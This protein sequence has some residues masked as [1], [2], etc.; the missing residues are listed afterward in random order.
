MTRF[1]R[2]AGVS[3]LAIC[4]SLGAMA[5]TV[6]YVSPGGDDTWAGTIG[7]PFKTLAKAVSVTANNSNTIIYLR[8]GMHN[9]S[10]RVVLNNNKNGT[11]VNRLRIFAYPGDPRPVLNFTALGLGSGNQGI[12]IKGS[13]WHLKGFDVYGAGDNGIIIEGGSNNIIENCAFYENQDSGLQI[14][15][16]AANNQIINCDSYFN[17]DATDGNAD[18]FACKLLAGTGNSFKGCRAWQNSDDGW[19]GLLTAP[20]DNI[21]TTYDSCWCFMNGYL[22]SGVASKGN[23]NGFKMGGNELRHNA[24]LTRCLSFYNRVKGF[25]QNNDIGDMILYNC[26]GYGN[27]PNFG[28]NNFDPAAGKVMEIR[29]SI[30]FA[31]K[32]SDVFR[33]VAI[34]TNN[35]WQSPFVTTAA[36]FL[37]VDTTGIRGP[38]KADGSLPDVNFMHLAAGSDL[39][40]GGMLVNLPYNGSAPDLGAFETASVLPVKLAGFSAVNKNKDVLLQWTLATETNNRGWEIERSLSGSNTWEDLGFVAGTGNSNQLTNYSFL[41]VSPAPGTYFYRLKQTDNDGKISYSS[42]LL[43][44]VGKKSIALD[45]AAYPNPVR[46]SGTIRFTVPGF[47]QVNLS[48]YTEAGQFVRTISNE[49]LDAGTYQKSFN[50]SELSSGRYIIKLQAGKDWV[51]SNLV[52]M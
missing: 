23:G 43:V 52:K 25:D 47:S 35:S 41:D 36:D 3:F 49:M 44:S 22:K 19:D 7:A 45:L 26:T 5:Q 4:F 2:L 27:K 38:R 48:L 50:A 10:A 51:T 24:K 33:A 31:G 21:S 34:R 28:M 1:L 11:A 9:Y 16:G 29:N 12:Q 20:N 15:D 17:K 40:N 18:G 14:D 6:Y 8:G 32:S 46:T 42:V 13:Y 39:I 30:S 37:S